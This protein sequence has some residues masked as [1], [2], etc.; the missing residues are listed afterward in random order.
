MTIRTAI[1]RSL[2]YATVALA[3]GMLLSGC[4]SAG[5]NTPDGCVG[6]PSFCTPYFGS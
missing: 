1:R 5:P 2:A 4:A 3:A 6:P